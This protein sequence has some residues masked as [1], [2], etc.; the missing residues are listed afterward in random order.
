MSAKL[1]FFKDSDDR[2]RFRVVGGNGEV[3]MSSEGYESKSNAVRGYLSLK[4][5]I[6]EITEAKIHEAFDASS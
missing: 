1:E 5:A 4:D 2:D 3:M 6:N